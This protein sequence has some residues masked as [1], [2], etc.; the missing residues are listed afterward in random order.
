M[1]PSPVL[2]TAAAAPSP[3]SAVATIA[4][5]SSLSSRMEIEQVST[6][7]NS[8][9]L[10]GSEAASRAVSA[11]PLTPPAQPRPNTGT[12]RTFSR[13]PSRGPTRASRLGVAMP[14]VETVTTPSI[15]SGAKPA[16]AIARPAASS[17]IRS[18]ASRYIA[19]RS[20]QPCGCSYHSSGATSRRVAISA[21][22]KTPDSRSN[23]DARPR[24]AR[25]PISLATPCSA[26]WGG[27]AVATDRKLQVG[28]DRLNGESGPGS[29][30]TLK[31]LSG[32]CSAHCNL[33]SC[34]S[35]PL[36]APRAL[37][38]WRQMGRRRQPIRRSRS[39]RWRPSTAPGRSRS[40]PA[41]TLHW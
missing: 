32:C 7:T 6:V 29:R 11:R 40:C 5:G 8:Q 38:I 28:M 34:W 18:D 17:Y 16:A 22:S 9:L 4:A 30:S 33:P 19:L 14:V 26:M 10:P 1:P 39:R 35:L 12:R 2:T 3:N 20:A 37:R 21:L 41:H 27:T 31:D 24:K 15:C 23:S 13:R 25:R 36:A